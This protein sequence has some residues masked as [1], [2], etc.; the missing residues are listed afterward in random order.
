VCS[1]VAFLHSLWF[2]SVRAFGVL[3][4][5]TAPRFF[6]R[7][8]A[9]IA[10]SLM[11]RVVG[12][13]CLTGIGAAAQVQRGGTVGRFARSTGL[14]QFREF[15]TAAL[16]ED[17]D[18]KTDGAEKK[19]KGRRRRLK[20]QLKDPITLTDN[21][22]E[23]L[24]FLLSKRPDAAGV[25]LGVK[26]RGCNGLA[27]TLDYADKFTVE[28][29]VTKDGVTVGVDPKALMYLAGS[30]M[31]FVEDELAAEFRFENPNAKGN[32]GCGESFNV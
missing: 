28:D 12:L 4:E 5:A 29:K 16:A 24:K 6:A 3:S 32:C 1:Y 7:R 15:G 8:F 31:D 20:R 23:R 9:L 10:R 21:A 22:V 19:Q 13:R 30:E 26:R 18:A 11:L 25:K 14:S 27:Y 2:L 17:V